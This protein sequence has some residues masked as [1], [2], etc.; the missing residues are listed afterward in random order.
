MDVPPDI[1]LSAIFSSKESHL[2]LAC[3]LWAYIP[4]K[5]DNLRREDKSANPVFWMKT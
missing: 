4:T 3:M 1:Q 2:S 5:N